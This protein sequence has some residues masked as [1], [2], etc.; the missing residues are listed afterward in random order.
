MTYNVD[1]E[2]YLLGTYFKGHRTAT[3]TRYDNWHERADLTLEQRLTESIIPIPYTPVFCN[4]YAD[5]EAKLWGSDNHGLLKQIGGKSSVTESNDGDCCLLNIGSRLEKLHHGERYQLSFPPLN[6]L[7]QFYGDLQ[8][9]QVEGDQTL[10]NK[11]MSFTK[12][13]DERFVGTSF[14]VT[15]ILPFQLA[16]EYENIEG[17]EL[18]EDEIAYNSWRAEKLKYPDVPIKG[19]LLPY[20]QACA[21]VFSDP[22]YF[23][24]EVSLIRDGL[25]FKAKS[26]RQSNASLIGKAIVSQPTS[27]QTQNGEN[28]TLPCALFS[29]DP[30][31]CND[32]FYL[33]R[34]EFWED[35][36]LKYH[37]KSE[38]ELPKSIKHAN[39][40]VI[41]AVREGDTIPQ[42]LYQYE[43][44]E[45]LVFKPSPGLGKIAC[46]CGDMVSLEETIIQQF[47]TQLPSYAEYATKGLVEQNG[48]KP[49]MGAISLSGTLMKTAESIMGDFVSLNGPHVPDSASEVAKTISLALW[50]SADK[51]QL[52]DFVMT[53][54]AMA[55]ALS[56]SKEALKQYRD[57]TALV[58]KGITLKDSARLIFTDKVMDTKYFKRIYHFGDEVA[59]NK[60]VV[61]GVGRLSSS[62]FRGSLEKR[63]GIIGTATDAYE[64]Y[65]AYKGYR[66]AMDSTEGAI[67]EL[68]NMAA[69][70]LEQVSLVQ[71]QDSEDLW[72]QKAENVQEILGDDANV[73]VDER[74][75]A[76]SLY[77]QFN[78][79]TESNQMRVLCA[80][81]SNICDKLNCL[82][83]ENPDY[84][85]IVEGF[86]GVIGTAAQNMTVSRNRAS[87]V[88]D[89]ITKGDSELQSRVIEHAYGK[90][91][92][93][94]GSEENYRDTSDK[95]DSS[96]LAIDRRVDI[97][98]IIPD[99]QITLPISRSGL[100]KM[101][102]LHQLWQALA[103]A[104]KDQ[105][106][107]LIMSSIDVMCG[108]ALLTP[109]APYAAMYF[110]G[111]E[112]GSLLTNGAE[113]VDDLHGQ[114]VFDEFASRLKNK[115]DLSVLSRLNKSLANAYN[116]E[117]HKIERQFLRADEVRAHL[118]SKVTQEELLKR[119][120]LRAYAI[121]S[122]TELLAIL[123][124]KGTIDHGMVQKYKVDDFIANYVMSDDWEVPSYSANTLAQSW[125]NRIEQNRHISYWGIGSLDSFN[126]QRVNVAF[127]SGFP[128]QTKL[129]LNDETTDQLVRFASN[130]DLNKVD[131]D[132]EDIGFSRVVLFNAEKGSWQSYHD[133]LVENKDNSLV[134]VSPITPVRVQVIVDPNFST[135][136]SAFIQTL[137]YRAEVGL[138]DA[139]GPEFDVLFLKKSVDD[140]TDPDNK[141]REYYEQAF[142]EMGASKREA[143]GISTVNDLELLAIEFDP[144]YWFGNYEIRGLKPLYAASVWDKAGLGWDS[145]WSGKSS[146]ELWVEQQHH[147]DM[148][149]MMNLGGVDLTLALMEFKLPHK[150]PI[151]LK[152]KLLYFGVDD[153]EYSQFVFDGRHSD[154]AKLSAEDFMIEE[155]VTSTSAESKESTPNLLDGH[156]ISV[157]QIELGGEKYLL[158]DNKQVR[159]VGDYDWSTEQDAAIYVALL[160]D[161]AAIDAY[162]TMGLAHHECQMTMQI[163][164]S[165]PVVHTTM[166]N[167]GTIRTGEQIHLEQGD[168][169]IE[170]RHTF[171]LCVD[172][173]KE[174]HLQDFGT[175]V[176]QHINDNNALYES[177]LK[178]Q[179][180]KYIYL[181]KFELNYT[182][183]TGKRVKG[184]RPYGKAHESSIRIGIESVS[185]TRVDGT[186]PTPEGS[187][188]VYKVKDMNTGNPW[189]KEP[190]ESEIE[191]RSA[192][193][194]WKSLDGEGR[195]EWLKAWMEDN[196][197]STGAPSLTLKQI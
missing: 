73:V 49:G 169:G 5:G 72:K 26:G 4:V 170:Q 29:L 75:V 58:Q 52:P 81:F 64:G 96:E 48:T 132:E 126:L 105:R 122:L 157:A 31:T 191:N 165:G 2:Y 162:E 38:V 45:K 15:K 118:E 93:R 40:K 111:K 7:S 159:L 192:Y 167:Y 27:N 54:T 163:S 176:I 23:G 50:E 10:A 20:T 189:V 149:Y 196:S 166:E 103:V 120:I 141:I 88:S 113:F 160:S 80:D 33:I 180:K 119:F 116:R 107:E 178:N 14:T 98:L 184:L 144:T 172:D 121:N 158:D 137:K 102:S 161:N 44:R 28:D 146:F 154:K 55:A 22:L 69:S 41:K 53:G 90:T 86:A 17:K 168:Y 46:V 16:P 135:H 18:T 12:H 76:V 43:L 91:K 130:F 106:D 9:E 131:L 188:M 177:K 147:R 42:N 138:F 128:V 79:A 190:T 104:E 99:Y 187:L 185:Q 150:Q 101:E 11:L 133:W 51:Q 195:K 183:P 95:T 164:E 127:N 125:I 87:K 100:M 8:Y 124:A 47:P 97:R 139:H 71:Q 117:E 1:N 61:R 151:K 3:G 70:Y 74:G 94:R 108:L 21:V 25:S 171:D 39:V 109:A 78:S 129:Y 19:F 63:L 179:D 89:A 37:Q 174:G 175:R 67:T 153:M 36:Y 85:L 112:A 32:G 84:Q 77:F 145:I 148:R 57:A 115:H 173:L 65:K 56:A 35:E 82:L 143:M 59:S 13:V 182:S 66:E 123:S 136:K 193:S 156:I 142:N 62:W 140:F 24:A 186:Y 194:Y 110:I 92:L 181:M 60:K 68:K 134:R 114:Q 155:F 152:Q 83:K 34:V 6:V 197:H 30:L